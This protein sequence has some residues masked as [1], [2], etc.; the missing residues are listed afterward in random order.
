MNIRSPYTTQIER[1]AY[2]AIVFKDGDYTVAEDDVGT[3][4]NEGTTVATV[5]QAALDEKNNVFFKDGTYDIGGTTLTLENKSQ[6]LQGEGVGSIIKGSADPL[7]DVTLTCECQLK[8]QR[9]GIH[10]T[11]TNKGIFVDNCTCR[12]PIWLDNVHFIPEGHAGT[13]LY[14]FGIANTQINNCSF[15]DT[16]V[17]TTAK[18][19]YLTADAT[20][21]SQDFYISGSNFFHLNYGIQAF[22]APSYRA[23]LAGLHIQNCSTFGVDYPIHFRCVDDLTIINNMIESQQ[24]GNEKGVILNDCLSC[25]VLGNRLS[26]RST[27][28]QL[29]FIGTDLGCYYNTVSTNYIKSY[30]KQGDGVLVDSS[31]GNKYVD[32]I[33][34]DNTIDNAVSAVQST[35]GTTYT[36]TIIFNGNHLRGCTD[37]IKGDIRTSIVVGNLWG[38]NCSSTAVNGT[39]GT[40]EIAHNL[41]T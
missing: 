22:A 28:A 1:G 35:K 33:I 13:L 2:S 32:A 11:T 29:E 8:M 40:S 9:M 15:Q 38:A 16:N 39:Y 26:T 37:N 34:N 18:G 25:R 31:P 3:I 10:T 24:T 4:I 17:S 6:Q 14:I 7:I 20:K 36:P 23:H 30:G 19:I 5:L 27:T 21:Y 41:K 12:M